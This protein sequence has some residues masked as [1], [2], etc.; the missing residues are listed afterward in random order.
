MRVA[1]DGVGVLAA[2]IAGW[3]AASELFQAGAAYAGDGPVLASASLL[4]AAE[5]RRACDAVRWTQPP[6]IEALEQAQLPHVGASA[7]F[8]SSSGNPEIVH[9]ICEALARTQRD[10]SPTRFHNSVHNAA[11][12]YWAIATG[13]TEASTS[14]ACFDG[15]F[16]AGMLEACTQAVLEQRPVMLVAYDL[17]YP[18]PLRRARAIAEPFSMAL[19]LQP[20]PTSRSIAV[21]E[22]ALLARAPARACLDDTGLEILRLSNP[23]ARSLPLLRALALRQAAQL[24]FEYLSDCALAVGL[25][26]C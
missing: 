11:A 3:R 5:R 18:D 22:V 2:G 26:P 19:V 1:V 6:G 13:C 16:S 8:A 23:A 10:V 20:Q 9:Q 4:P 7:V 14:I 12:G 21:L 25:R 17:P 24:E 15:T